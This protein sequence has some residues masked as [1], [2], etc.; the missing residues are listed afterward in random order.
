MTDRNDTPGDR[1]LPSGDLGAA[2]GTPDSGHSL[3]DGWVQFAP[4]EAEEGG[5]SV[6]RGPRRGF[7]AE[8]QLAAQSAP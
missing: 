4:R 7:P 8:S 6:G 3:D 2:D 5:L 1:G